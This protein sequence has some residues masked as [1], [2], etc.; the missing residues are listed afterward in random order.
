M[1]VSFLKEKGIRVINPLRIKAYF[2]FPVNDKT[3]LLCY[4]FFFYENNTRNL[5]EQTHLFSLFFKT[6]I[7]FHVLYEFWKIL[8][9][10]LSTKDEILHTL[11]ASL[12]P[13]LSAIFSPCVLMPFTCTKIIIIIK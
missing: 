2:I 1:W 7:F 3:W 4:C 5:C 9:I 12:M 11:N 8:F 6:I 13:P 10:D